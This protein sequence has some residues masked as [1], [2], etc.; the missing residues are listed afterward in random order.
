[1]AKK[2]KNPICCI[3]GCECENEYGNNPWPIV[4]DA[5]ARCCDRC[6]QTAVIPARIQQLIEA[7]RRE[8]LKTEKISMRISA[9]D[10]KMLDETCAKTGRSRAN[11]IT[12]LIRTAYSQIVEDDQ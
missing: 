11:L 6:D 8:N 2:K 1:M 5:D 12:A 4:K 7:K 9:G 10:L 3:C